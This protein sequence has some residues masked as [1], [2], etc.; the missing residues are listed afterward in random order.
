MGCYKLHN[1]TTLQIAHTSNT[2]RSREG[3]SDAGLYKYRFGG[4]EFQDELGLNVYDYDNRVY[5]QAL[6]RFW[7]MD[8]LAEQGRRWSPYNYCFNNP[9]YFQDPDGMWPKMP[10]WSDVKKSYNEAKATVAKTYNQTKASITKTYN[11]TKASVTKTYNETKASVA[12]TYNE[13]KKAVVETT[14]K[15]VASTKET[16]KEGQ[17][18]VKDNKK[19]ILNVANNMQDAGD[20]IAIAG[21]GAAVVG[22]PIAGVGAAPGATVAAIGNGIGL[23]GSG[24]EIATNLIAGDNGAAGQEAGFVAGGMVI[25]AVVDRAL[26]GP[27]PDMSKEA[28]TILKEGVNVKTILTER[29]IK[30]SQEEKK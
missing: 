10:S 8:P 29:A 17:Q 16:L 22:A 18:W 2:A 11:E 13:T 9:I 30:N 19:E 3:K 23:L 12:K 1:Y 7:Q 28:T 20:G 6:G 21:Y 25:D 26:P 27:T 24:I 14:N 4:N 5:D 15:V